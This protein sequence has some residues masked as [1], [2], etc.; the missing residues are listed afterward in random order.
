MSVFRTNRHISS[1]PFSPSLPL[2]HSLCLPDDLEKEL[3]RTFSVPEEVVC[4]VWHRYMSNTYEL[5]SDKTQTLQDA[6]LYNMQ[7]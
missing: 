7:V 6:G 3:R 5:L 4:R 2:P 1:L